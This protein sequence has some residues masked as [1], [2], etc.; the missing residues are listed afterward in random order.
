MKGWMGAERDPSM[1]QQEE[2]TGA[3]FFLPKKDPVPAIF[4]LHP[5]VLQEEASTITWSPPPKNM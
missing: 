4:S 3:G 2:C 5:D 1:E